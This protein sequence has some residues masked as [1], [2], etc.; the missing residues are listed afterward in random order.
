MYQSLG[1][2]EMGEAI[3]DAKAEIISHLALLETEHRPAPSPREVVEFLARN[4]NGDPFRAAITSLIAS[5]VIE[6][7]P[8]WKLRLLIET[9]AI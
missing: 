2:L 5:R 1:M 8:E 4:R 3:A 6:A 7:T 9:S